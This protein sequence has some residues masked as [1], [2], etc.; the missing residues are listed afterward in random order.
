METECA[1]TEGCDRVR[2]G[3]VGCFTVLLV[4]EERR[5]AS[6]VCTPTLLEPVFAVL[7][8]CFFVM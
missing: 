1:P 3:C 7:Q 8:S 2:E 6:L 4:F 5:A